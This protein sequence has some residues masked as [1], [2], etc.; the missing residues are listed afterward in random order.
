MGARKLALIVTLAVAVIAGM[1]GYAHYRTSTAAAAEITG[2]ALDGTTIDLTA[3]RGKPVVV[4]FFG[5]WCPWCVR[6]SG[7]LS[8]FAKAHPD[9]QFLGIAY[10][11]T[12][13]AVKS[14]AAKY[15][16]TYPMMLDGGAVVG[17]FKIEGYPTT[18]FFD[19]R[20][21]EKAR[22]VGASDGANFEA[23]LKKAL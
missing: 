22:I 17:R 23:N 11:D 6:E 12:A 14:F 1:W 4:N 13:V 2:T 7:E 3:Y 5:T 21:V 10:D 19:A 9:V 8:A 20:G 16:L 18:L 15:G